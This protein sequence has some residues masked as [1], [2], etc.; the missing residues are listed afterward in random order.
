M[1]HFERFFT[2]L[3]AYDFNARL[4]E[5]PSQKVSIRKAVFYDESCCHCF[6]KKCDV[7]TVDKDKTKLGLHE[8]YPEKT[9]DENLKAEKKH[10]AAV[11]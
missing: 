7:C 2:A 3:C 10:F 1:Q 6:L 9:S 5:V 4:H 8:D 11:G